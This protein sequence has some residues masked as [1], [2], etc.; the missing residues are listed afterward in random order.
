MQG[1]EYSAGCGHVTRTGTIL[2]IRRIHR[3]LNSVN[4][5]PVGIDKSNWNEISEPNVGL[6]DETLALSRL[7]NLVVP[8]LGI[9][10]NQALDSDFHRV[11]QNFLS[12]LKFSLIKRLRNKIQ[13]F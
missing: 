12:H 9:N 8:V 6:I 7:R 5:D 1:N 2:M 13:F 11:V 3:D 4:L 10:R